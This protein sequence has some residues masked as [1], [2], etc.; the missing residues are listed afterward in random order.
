[1][2]SHPQKWD[3]L[4][5]GQYLFEPPTYFSKALKAEFSP[6]SES[7]KFSLMYEP[8]FSKEAGWPSCIDRL[9]SLDLLPN[10]NQ[11]KE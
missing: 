6:V 11:A 7:W 4:A 2:P 3:L 5:G 10:G 8:L 9:W 1:M